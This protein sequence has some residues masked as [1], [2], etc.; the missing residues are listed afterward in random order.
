[1]INK[2]NYII[3]LAHLAEGRVLDC[4]YKN[5]EKRMEFEYLCSDYRRILNKK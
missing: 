2:D 5:N 1:M 3:C 4:L